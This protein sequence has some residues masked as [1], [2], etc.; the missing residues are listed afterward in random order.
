MVLPAVENIRSR[1]CS[2]FGGGIASLAR[3][4]GSARISPWYKI[5]RT[6]GSLRLSHTW[7]RRYHEGSL[8]HAV[9]ASNPALSQGGRVSRATGIDHKSMR[10]G[11][12][13]RK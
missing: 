7:P 3:A 11:P 2:R 12:R 5:G 1:I 13:E 6:R 8:I 10:H 4:Q 9:H